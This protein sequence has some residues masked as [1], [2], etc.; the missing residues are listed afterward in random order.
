M[1]YNTYMSIEVYEEDQRYGTIP[2][3]G[4]HLKLLT[5][6]Q[7]LIGSV[8]YNGDLDPHPTVTVFPQSGEAIQFPMNIIGKIRAFSLPGETVDASGKVALVHNYAIERK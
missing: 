3:E 5:W 6:D 7:K 4:G 8:A 1:A 2:N